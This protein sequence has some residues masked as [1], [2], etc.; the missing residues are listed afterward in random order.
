M[1]VRRE[2]L[3]LVHTMVSRSALALLLVLGLFGLGS[4][5]QNEPSSDVELMNYYLWTL[6]NAGDEDYQV[7]I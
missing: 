3:S 4:K 6:D 1:D 7:D 2:S 5:A